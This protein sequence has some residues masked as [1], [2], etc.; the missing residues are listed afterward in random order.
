[1]LQFV[2]GGAVGPLV[3]V[4]GTGTALPMALIIAGCAGGAVLAFALLTRRR[5]AAPP[6]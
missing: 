3:G 1:V 6:D 5:A 2:I 4:A